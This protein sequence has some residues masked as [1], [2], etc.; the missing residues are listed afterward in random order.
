MAR[1]EKAPSPLVAIASAQLFESVTL[2]GENGRPTVMRHI[3]ANP[4]WRVAM[5]YNPENSMLSVTPPNGAT[6]L[7]PA[8][9]IAAM[10]PA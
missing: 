7:I 4:K 10:E 3:A 6:K 5:N 1:L 2:V 9:N 8:G